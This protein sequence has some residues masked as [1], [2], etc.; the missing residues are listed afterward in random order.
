M[1]LFGCLL[2]SWTQGAPLAL[3][4]PERFLASPATWVEDLSA[5][6]ATLTAGPNFGLERLAR[7]D[8]VGRGCRPFP[9][10]KW[11]VGGEPVEWDTLQSVARRLAPLGIELEAFSP[12]YGLAEATLAVTM[13]RPAEA[14]RARTVGE[15]T[16]TSVGHPLRGVEVTLDGGE[17]VVRSP[18]LA[19]GYAGDPG[20]TAARLGG[21]R[22]RTG[23]TGILDD[24]GAL[25]VTG[26]LDDMIA[27]GGR[28]IHAREIEATLARVGGVRPGACALVD[29][30]RDRRRLVVLAEPARDATD[31]RGVARAAVDAVRTQHGI[32]VDDCWIVPGGTIPKTPS[33]KLQRY[34]CRELVERDELD[35]LASA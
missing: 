10:R 13:V 7:S 34:R 20:L 33:G 2:L 16:V 28:K 3:S 14:P 11:V 9:M 1:G 26:R 31:L 29:A 27:M 19:S 12:A 15:R 8:G 35:V 23:D 32:R 5:F 4:R 6:G 18:S 21:G 17:I 25:Y 24:S 22:L 30:D